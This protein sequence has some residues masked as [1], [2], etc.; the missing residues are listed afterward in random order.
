MYKKSPAPSRLYFEALWSV[1]RFPES[2]HKKITDVKTLID[3][4]KVKKKRIAHP[5]FQTLPLSAFCHRRH[6]GPKRWQKLIQSKVSNGSCCMFIYIYKYPV[7]Q[8]EK[9]TGSSKKTIKWMQIKGDQQTKT[10]LSWPT[11]ILSQEAGLPNGFVVTMSNRGLS[12]PRAASK[13]PR[14]GLPGSVAPQN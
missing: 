4:S 11:N 5:K 8:N 2:P 1:R 14:S 13:C 6:P 7:Y 3:S 9:M 12:C 10:R